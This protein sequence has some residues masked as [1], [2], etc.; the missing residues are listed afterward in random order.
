MTTWTWLLVLVGLL[1]CATAGPGL[2][3]VQDDPRY[4][5]CEAHCQAQ[6]PV[7]RLHCQAIVETR[8]GQVRIVC[9]SAGWRAPPAL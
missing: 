3:A 7:G 8:P 6:V 1:G 9:A 5:A 2:P 4:G